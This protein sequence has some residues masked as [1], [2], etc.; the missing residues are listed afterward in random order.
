VQVARGELRA[1]GHA[2]GTGDGAAVSGESQLEL[3]GVAPSELLVFDL[4]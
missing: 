3:V 1:N 2:L 4:R